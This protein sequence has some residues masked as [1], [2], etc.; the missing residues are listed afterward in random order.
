METGNG[1]VPDRSRKVVYSV[2][3]T[4]ICYPGCL[5]E[6]DDGKGN[7]LHLLMSCYIAKIRN[8]VRLQTPD[9]REASV[10]Q[11]YT[12]SD[13]ATMSLSARYLAVTT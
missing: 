12:Y 11:A 10:T 7:W 6:Y 13:T 2:G 4:G 9:S 5:D 8:V 1:R 3:I